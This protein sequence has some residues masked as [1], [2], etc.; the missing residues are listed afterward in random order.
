MCER[1]AGGGGGEHSPLA[2][3]GLV[4]EPREPLRPRLSMGGEEEKSGPGRAALPF[5]DDESVMTP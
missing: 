3:E 5:R 4:K 2:A 1:V